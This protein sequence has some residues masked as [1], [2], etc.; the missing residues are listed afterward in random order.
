MVSAPPRDHSLVERKAFKKQ[1]QSQEFTLI[2][3]EMEGGWGPRKVL[4]EELFKLRPKEKRP[5]KEAGKEGFR[6]R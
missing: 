6:Q 1:K 2:L 4:E 3:R 5:R